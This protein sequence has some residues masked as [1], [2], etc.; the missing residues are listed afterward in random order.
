MQTIATSLLRSRVLIS[1]IFLNHC[2][3][4]QSLARTETILCRQ[5]QI[6]DSFSE[7]LRG[8]NHNINAYDSISRYDSIFGEMLQHLTAGNT[9][10]LH[11]PFT[12]L[13]N[14]GVTIATSADGLLRIYSWDGQTG[15]TAHNANNI[16][17]YKIDGKVYSTLT[18]VDGGPGDSYS[19]IYLF[20]TGNET[21]YLAA[22]EAIIATLKVHAA[23]E[24]LQL[25]SG[26]LRSNVPLIRTASGMTGTLGFDYTL[27]SEGDANF[28]FNSA[29]GSITFPV[30]L[31][32][33]RV[34]KRKISYAFNGEYFV[35]TNN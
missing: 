31:E 18:I 33:G 11:Y 27:G 32:E 30:V 21:Y 28:H 9:A 2:A 4:G 13:H 25:D 10:S 16:Y 14:E 24:I 26:Q 5:L 35:R 17:Q 8:P 3:L 7:M 12:R 23:L 6:I 20:K 29:T 19:A 34:T 1:L 15:G 22:S